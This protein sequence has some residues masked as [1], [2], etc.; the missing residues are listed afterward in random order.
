MITL[1]TMEMRKLQRNLSNTV[2]IDISRAACWSDIV[3]MAVKNGFDMNLKIHVTCDI[4][5]RLARYELIFETE[6]DELLFKMRF[7]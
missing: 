4:N 5:T 3:T 1:N 7:I 6:D 2:K